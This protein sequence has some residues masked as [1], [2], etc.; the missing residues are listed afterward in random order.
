MARSQRL[1]QLETRLSELRRHMLPAPFD[2]TGSYTDRQFDRTR[3]YRLLAHAEIE[4]CLE[5][6]AMST[7][8]GAFSAWQIDRR[9][10]HCLIALLAYHEGDLGA[11]PEEISA[12]RA[13]ATPLRTRLKHA[14]DQYNDWVRTKNNGIREPN[15]LRLLLP[16]GILESDLDPAWLQTI[17]GF[18]SARG[19]T[20]HQ[21]LRTQQPPDPAT[22]HQTV[23]AIVTGLRKVDARLQELA[24]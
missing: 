24:I 18:G 15:V 14:R 3:G 9:P 19:D 7:V 16:M 1:R 5:E 10:R 12:S 17:D 11:M 2:P 13:S 20:A 8:N 6:L 4:A 23:A 22:E 21:A